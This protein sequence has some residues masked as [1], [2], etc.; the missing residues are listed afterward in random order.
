MKILV[1]TRLLIVSSIIF[2]QGCN[3]ESECNKQFCRNSIIVF[4]TC[5]RA[6]AKTIIITDENNEA[7]RCKIKNLK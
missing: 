5:T 6:G 3:V 7:I 1:L 2:L 4:D